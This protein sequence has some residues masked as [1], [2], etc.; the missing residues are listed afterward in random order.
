M[1]VI[2]TRPHAKKSAESPA[3]YDAILELRRHGLRVLRTGQRAIDDAALGNL[4]IVNGKPVTS[5]ELIAM[6]G[7]L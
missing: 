6:A 7:A 4:H 1:T 2:R 3:L 5:V